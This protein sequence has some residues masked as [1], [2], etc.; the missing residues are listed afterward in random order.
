MEFRILR[1]KLFAIIFEIQTSYNPLLEAKSS[2]IYINRKFQSLT[3]NEWK[4]KGMR[5]LQKK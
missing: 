5:I 1:S 2:K 4:I 3:R